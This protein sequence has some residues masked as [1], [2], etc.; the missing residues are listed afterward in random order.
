MPLPPGVLAMSCAPRSCVSSSPTPARSPA[1]TARR[2]ARSPVA[3]KDPAQGSEAAQLQ[4][5]NLSTN[6]KTITLPVGTDIRRGDRIS[7]GGFT[8]EAVKIGQNRTDEVLLDV[9]AVEIR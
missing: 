2:S 1:R 9:V 5:S 3:I 8:Y 6:V 4:G 7:K